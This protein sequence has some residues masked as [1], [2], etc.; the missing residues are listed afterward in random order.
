MVTQVADRPGTHKV[1]PGRVY[2]EITPG[3]APAQLVGASVKLTIA[4][5]STRQA[6]LVVPRHRAVGRR[7]RQLAGPGAASQRAHANT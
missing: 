1:D 4:V 5:K 2:L 6:V 3:T 7:G